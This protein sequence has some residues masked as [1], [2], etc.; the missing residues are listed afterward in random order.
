MLISPIK[1]YKCIKIRYGNIA[2]VNGND[3]ERKSGLTHEWMLFVVAPVGFIK[4]VTFKLHE[5]F[6]NNTI[7]VTRDN[8]NINNT[9]SNTNNT[10]NNTLSNT[11]N[12]NNSKDMFDEFTLKQKGWGEF[13][14]QLKITL[15]NNDKLTTSHYLQ[16]HENKK[17]DVINSTLIS[18]K[19][20]TVFYKGKY[21]PANILNTKYANE[22]DEYK[23]IDKCIDYVLDQIDKYL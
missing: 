3:I 11:N 2:N 20:D 18:E 14:V 15:F 19:V 16:L 8:I 12:I 13:T 6:L 4:S 17:V 10:N 23:R 21:T 5:S 1:G 22:Q 9:L 7:T